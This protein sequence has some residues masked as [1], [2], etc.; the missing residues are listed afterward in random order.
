MYTGN[1]E[2]GDKVYCLLKSAGYKA[3][4]FT[5]HLKLEFHGI[6]FDVKDQG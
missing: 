5:K 2:V 3:L 6:P 4:S 1:L